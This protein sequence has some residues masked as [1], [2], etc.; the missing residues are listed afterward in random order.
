MRRAAHTASQAL[1]NAEVARLVAAADALRQFD[2]SYTQSAVDRAQTIVDAE[3]QAAQDEAQA[4][5]AATDAISDNY[6]STIHGA[7]TIIKNA[8]DK[9]AD[10]IK[11]LGSTFQ[12][13]AYGQAIALHQDSLGGIDAHYDQI[14][15]EAVETVQIA[16]GHLAAAIARLKADAIAAANKIVDDFVVSIQRRMS[17]AHIPGADLSNYHTDAGHSR[18][19]FDTDLLMAGSAGY[20][21]QSVISRAQELRSV[22]STFSGPMTGPMSMMTHDASCVFFA[23]L[24]PGANGQGQLVDKVGNHVGIWNPALGIV[25]RSVSTTT[26]GVRQK[27]MSYDAV[28]SAIDNEACD[29]AQEWNGFFGGYNGDVDPDAMPTSQILFEFLV[30]EELRNNNGGLIGDIAIAVQL[31]TDIVG[32]I[33]PTGIADGVNAA[34]QLAAGNNQAAAMATLSIAIPFGADKLARLANKVPAGAI[35]TTANAIGNKFDDAAEAAADLRRSA[36]NASGAARNTKVGCDK[37]DGCF[38]GDTIVLEAADGNQS[39]HAVVAG[40]FAVLGMV[41]Y[42]AMTSP[43]NRSHPGEE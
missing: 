42:A 33:D 35:K 30:D 21:R 1:V 31:A 15:Q 7:D 38:V 9:K 16:N 24:Q 6:E 23:L 2:T 41:G 34:V 20:M 8:E 28:K 43:R 39:Q 25:T 26:G 12:T 19:I 36:D 14:A 5:K 17:E 3:K 18:P 4:N 40:T 11:D 13:A 37:P 27:S 10:G 32:M 29:T 22:I